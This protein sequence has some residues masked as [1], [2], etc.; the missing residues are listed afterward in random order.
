MLL[1]IV[2]SV[3]FEGILPYYGINDLEL[4]TKIL[5]EPFPK[6][7]NQY[8][9]KFKNA[10]ERMLNKV[11]YKHITYFIYSFCLYLFIC[12]FIL[13]YRMVLNE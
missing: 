2:N 12:L 3:F 5:N 8:S 1:L 4:Q 6:M 9:Q 10:T 11:S 7:K 13:F